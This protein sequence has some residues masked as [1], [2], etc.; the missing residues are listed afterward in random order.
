MRD[1]FVGGRLTPSLLDGTYEF[2]GSSV[3]EA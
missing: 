1:F 2:V 3:S